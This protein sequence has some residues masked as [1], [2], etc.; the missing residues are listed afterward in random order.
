MHLVDE[1]H[2]ELLQ[3]GQDGGE[4]ARALDGGAGGNAHGNAH[5]RGDD[6]G[7]RG[8]AETGWAVEEQVVQRLVA[9]EGGLRGD[10]QV[11]LQLLLSDELSQPLRTQRVVERRL[12]VLQVAG[13]DAVGGV[14][15]GVALT[16]I[17]LSMS[18]KNASASAGWNLT[19]SLKLKVPSPRILV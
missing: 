14:A 8:L 2:I 17:R 13:G 16:A 4:V 18:A 19:D 9:L 1:E 12:V 7:Q 5:L 15:H 10:V 11:V 3:T 6:V